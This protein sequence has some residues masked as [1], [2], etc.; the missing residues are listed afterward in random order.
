MT[1]TLRDYQEDMI[2][3]ARLSLR[4]HR[5]VLVQAPTGAGKT[6]L[7]AAM[8]GNANA[9]GKSAVFICHRAEL[10]D[11]TAET[12]EKVG[13]KHS[14]CAAGRPFNPWAPA[15]ICSVDTLKNRLDRMRVPDLVVWDEAHHIAAGGWRKVRSTWADTYHIGLSATPERLD[16][17]GLDD[18]FEDLVLGP[19]VSWLIERKYLSPY[20]AFSPSAPD[21]SA[22]KKSMGDFQRAALGE[23]M[24][25]STIVGDA[26]RHYLKH[27][28]GKRA[29]AFCVSIK[30]SEHVAAS[31]RS[32]GVLAVSLDGTTNPYERK[33]ALDAFR[34]GEIQV[35]CN[36]DLF[37]E[38]FDLPAIEAV[39]L[40]RPTQSLGLFLQQVGRALRTFPG[41]THATILD[42]AGNLMRHGLP[43]DDRQ[44]SLAGREK[45]KGKAGSSGEPA[46]CCPQCFATHSPRP[47]CPEC[48]HVYE[49]EERVVKQVDGDLK[50]IDAA[51]FRRQRM[52]EQGRARSLEDLVRLATAKGYRSPEKWAAHVWTARQAKG[53]A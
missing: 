38:G 14:F 7:S 24:D 28:R 44:W 30:H 33:R 4:T 39:I 52:I 25:G 41:K 13:I 37:G 16:G 8:I 20:R 3:R 18:L 10:V 48:G 47:K 21:L 5:S 46:R 43:D 35:L 29:V 49:V 2:G 40:L 51:S 32:A 12:F 11:Q 31:F 27:A 36:V 42:H 15:I 9:K 23:I 45:K 26:V 6:A 50:E 1:I 17:K 19:S 53:A 22:V 34:R